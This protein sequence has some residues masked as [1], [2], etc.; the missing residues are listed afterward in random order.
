MS[1]QNAF[2]VPLAADEQDTVQRMLEQDDLYVEVVD[3]GFHPNPTI[4]AGDKR[5]QVRFPM[6]F[7]RPQGIEIPVTRFRLRLK[8]R[9][10]RTVAETVEST[11]YNNQPLYVTAGM[12]IDL[13]WD[14][15][16]EKVDDEVKN[17]VLPGIRGKKV[18]EIE[19]DKV[20]RKDKKE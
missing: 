13:V 19:G 18:A 11:V 12:Q 9:D 6:E 7:T 8:M 15:A 1:N 14:L 3:W 2:Y 5:I 10:G 17:L 4:T 16:L 20:V